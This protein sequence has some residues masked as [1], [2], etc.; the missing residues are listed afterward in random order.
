MIVKSENSDHL[1]S[2]AIFSEVVLIY[3]DPQMPLAINQN[4]LSCYQP[5]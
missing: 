3:R 1:N 2:F 4:S 5:S